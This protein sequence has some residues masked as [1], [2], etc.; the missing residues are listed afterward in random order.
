MIPV[1]DDLRVLE[2]YHSPQVNVRVR[3]NTNESPSPPPAAWRD[4][5][6]AELSRVEWHRYP[7]RAATALRTAIADWHGVDPSQVFAANGSNE[8]IQTLLL[9]YAGPGRTVATFEPTYQLHSHIG[10]ITG[11]TVV[12]GERSADFTLDPAEMHR[13]VRD[14]QP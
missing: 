8:V 10:R 5:F 12:E 1:R 3:L 13:V 7:D 4:A 9:T 6:A 14:A 2:G 11:S